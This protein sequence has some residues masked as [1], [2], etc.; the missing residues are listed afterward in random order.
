MKKLHSASTLSLFSFPP[1]ASGFFHLAFIRNYYQ[2]TRFSLAVIL[3]LS[4]GHLKL[5]FKTQGIWRQQVL[6]PLLWSV[7]MPEILP[8]AADTE[9][10]TP[11]PESNTRI[12]FFLSSCSRRSHVYLVHFGDYRGRWLIYICC[13]YNI[14]KFS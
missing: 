11:L 6:R 10:I 5:P 14:S 7:S 9:K 12:S 1:E 3:R 2:Q 4:T 13:S 8:C